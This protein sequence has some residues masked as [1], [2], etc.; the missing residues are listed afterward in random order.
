MSRSSIFSFESYTAFRPRVPWTLLGVLGLVA[1][2]ELGL[3]S[4]SEDFIPPLHSRM[5]IF[6]WFEREVIPAF[7]RPQVLVMGSSRAADGVTP[8]FLDEALG[9]PEGSTLNLALQ[10]GTGFDA[11]RFYQRNRE[12]FR[13]AR[14]LLINVDEWQFTSRMGPGYRYGACAPWGERWHFAERVELIRR[15][16]ESDGAWAARCRDHAERLEQQRNRLL[17][18]GAFYARSVLHYLPKSLSIWMGGKARIRV[19]DENAQV[20]LAGLEVGPAEIPT[21]VF[22]KQVRDFYDGFDVHPLMV[23]HL[24]QLIGLA[25][26]DD[27]RVLLLQMPNRRAYQQEVDRLAGMEYDRQSEVICALGRRHDVPVFCFRYPEACGLEERDFADY[28]HMAVR[29]SRKFTAFLGKLIREKQLLPADADDKRS[30]GASL[31]AVR[32]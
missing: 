27:L 6:R 4:L 14:L 3:R 11:L 22:E 19:L 23:G 1:L 2:M 13:K 5:G 9:L 20:R 12:R 21:S 29:G 7:E 15:K 10:G 25:K 17:L 30:A 28:G 26:A 16:G 24:E 18:D 31:P 32:K 8:R